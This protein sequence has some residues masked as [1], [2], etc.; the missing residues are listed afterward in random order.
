MKGIRTDDCLKTIQATGDLATLNAFWRVVQS[1]ARQ[2]PH[3]FESSGLWR[4]R[5]YDRKDR[6]VDAD[7]VRSDVRRRSSR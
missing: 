6:G 2:G 5:P 4:L 3:V 7:F 1:G